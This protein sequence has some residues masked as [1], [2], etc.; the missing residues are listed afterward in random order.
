M[1]MGMLVVGGRCG[2]LSL[3][4]VNISCDDVLASASPLHGGVR[5]PG[6]GGQSVSTLPRHLV[7]WFCGE[8]RGG[9]CE[10]LDAKTC[11]LC[12][13]RGRG[14]WMRLFAVVGVRRGE[15]EAREAVFGLV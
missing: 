15:R 14:A 8:G 9:P 3:P 11:R 5:A 4:G 12:F 2:L 6:W 7:G 13:L 1:V 10:M